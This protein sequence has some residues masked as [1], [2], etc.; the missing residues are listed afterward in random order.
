MLL[1]K[2][3]EWH[4]P[5]TDG[6]PSSFG[7]R[8]TPKAGDREPA[9]TRHGLSVADPAS[10]WTA[11]LTAEQRDALGCLVWE[12]AC[13]R[14]TAPAAGTLQAWADRVAARVTGLVEPLTVVEVDLARDEALLRSD[15]PSQRGAGLYYY[16]VL[17]KGRREALVRRYQGS[18]KAGDRREQVSFAVTYEVLANLVRT[19][20]AD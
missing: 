6:P 4:P 15:E 1:Q 16:E 7:F 8:A 13:R 12:L 5:P 3:S 10:G 17:L 9:P 20:V 14:T 2:L 11:A 19:L 18:H